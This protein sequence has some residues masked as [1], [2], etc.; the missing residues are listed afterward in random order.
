MNESAQRFTKLGFTKTIVLPALLIFLIPGISLAFFLYAEA[1]YDAE[2]RQSILAMIQDDSSLDPQARAEAIQYFTDNPISTLITQDK[3]ALRTDTDLVFYYAFFR[4]MIRIS[5]VSIVGGVAVLLLGGVCVAIS[6]ASPAAQYFSLL[7]VWNVLRLYAAVQ[8][9][10]QGAMLV[11]L[12]FWITALWFNVYIVKLIILVAILAIGAAASLIHAIFKP[13]KVDIELEGEV[14]DRTTAPDF[15]SELRGICDQVGTALPDQVVAG[16]DDNFFV[17]ELPLKVGDQVYRGRTLY[18]SLALLKQLHGSEAAA[19]LAHEMAHFSGN[20]TL[21]SKKT[22]PLL[23]RYNNYLQSLYEGGISR[24]IF[25]FMLCFR[26]LFALSFGKVSRKREF[27]AD[28][29]AAHITS[30]R[31]MVGALLRIGAYSTY[32]QTIE[33]EFADREQVL[34][35]A[36]ISERIESGFP[37]FAV[38]FLSN[39][40]ISELQTTHPFDSHPPLAQR[41]DAVGMQLGSP[42]TER[43]LM[44]SGDGAWHRRISSAAELER[45]QWELFEARFRDYHEATLPY[46]F[47]PE[48]E[49]E[50]AIVEKAF[51]EIRFDGSGSSLIIDYEKLT[52]DRWSQPLY[53]REIASFTMHDGNS[54]QITYDRSNVGSE[55]IQLAKFGKQ[56]Q[57][58]LDAVMNYHSRFATAREYQQHRQAAQLGESPLAGQA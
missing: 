9:I 11:A 43:L 3:F 53:Y 26:G 46:R 56:Q 55:W 32:R 14:L 22:T 47:L 21:F 2:A 30:S 20:D 17:T 4:W 28:R 35:T 44:T 57:A 15:W 51:P 19:V 31:D 1:R 49:E 48:T 54:L 10:A 36:N 58:V 12:S 29:I 24:P 41:L 27:R 34:Q 18:V 13:V 39:P 42:D 37:Q 23:I 25:Y 38:S 5:A 6:F 33:R 40:H 52:H 16:I 45:R 50:R 8:T 7:T